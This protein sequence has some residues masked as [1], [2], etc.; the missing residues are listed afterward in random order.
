MAYD[1]LNILVFHELVSYNYISRY[2]LLAIV[3]GVVDLYST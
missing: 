3:Y 1:F 2:H